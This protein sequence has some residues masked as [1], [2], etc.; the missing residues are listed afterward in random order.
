MNF[1]QLSIGIAER[2]EDR[3]RTLQRERKHSIL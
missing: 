3:V 2:K 1:E